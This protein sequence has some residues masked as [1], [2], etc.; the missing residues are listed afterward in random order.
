MAK[1]SDQIFHGD[2]IEAVRPRGGAAGITGSSRDRSELGAHDPA[3]PSVL[4]A[5]RGVR[6]SF[7]GREV[8]PGLDWSLREGECAVILGRSGSGKSVFLSILLGFL[9]PDA[10]EVFRHAS[11]GEDLFAG[12]AVMFQED[13]L[14]DDRSVEANLALA[15]LE[16]A[17]LFT[18]PFDEGTD[19]AIDAALSDVGLDPALV[20]EKPPSALS[21]GM[22]R[23]VALARA[24]VRGPRIL[25]ADEPTTGLDPETSDTI[26]E[27]LAEVVARR[28][29]TAVVVTH[30]ATCAARLGDPILCFPPRPRSLPRFEAAASRPTRDEVLAWME[31][32]L[33]EADTRNA[34]PRASTPEPAPEPASAPAPYVDWHGGVETLG[35]A[36]LALEGLAVPPRPRALLRELR[37][38][39]LGTI[40]L[41]LLVFGLLGLVSLVQVERSV[42]ELGFSNRVPELLAMML[43]RLAPVMTGFL[44][45]GRCGSAVAAQ[46]GWMT[47]SGQM[48]ALRTLRVEPGRELLPPLFAAWALAAPPLALLGLAAGAGAA[49]SVLALGLSTAQITPRF[50]A[51]E[52]LEAIDSAVLLSMFLK[53]EL[54]AAGMVAIAWTAGTW[55][56]RSTLD[57]AHA[58]TVALVLSFV[59][60]TVADAAVSL[61]I[62]D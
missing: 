10:G 53:T 57:V 23:R 29:L 5:L 48:R 6:K 54:M 36:L 22:R 51:R 9:E 49:W 50:F 37:L 31:R 61:A 17:D 7:A 15:L 4:L 24:L 44:L 12:V 20:R 27:L 58:I 52:F 14:L 28:G 30:D 21:G 41:V 62:P 18:G 2:E 16:R 1:P 25:V 3:S 46:L 47:L 45:A 38:W 19:R 35:R 42:A 56:K 55:R 34:A 60:N 26:F 32:T 11:L 8:L 43:T 33:R 40:P 39:G 59:W 13:A